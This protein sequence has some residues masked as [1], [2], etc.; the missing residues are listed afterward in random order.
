MRAG[1]LR[2]SIAD[3]Q[4]RHDENGF[5]ELQESLAEAAPPLD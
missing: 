2:H 4:H 5:W 3:P 1:K